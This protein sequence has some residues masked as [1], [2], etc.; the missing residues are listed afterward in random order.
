ML[1]PL[2][3][4]MKLLV[5]PNGVV[6]VMEAAQQVNKL[7]EKGFPWPNYITSMV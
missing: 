5:N 1:P 7:M 4:K 3:I 2:K 6:L